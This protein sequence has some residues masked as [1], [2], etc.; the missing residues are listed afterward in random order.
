MKF[1]NSIRDKIEQYFHPTYFELENESHKHKVPAGSETHFRLLVVS[2]FFKEM[3]RV[4]RARKA[5]EILADELSSGV[6]ALSERFFT[7]DEW[8]RLDDA[9]KLMISPKC[10]GGGKG[11]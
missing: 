1:E 6:H 4:E 5:H 8:G 2:D 10:L 7:L 3:T 9:Q 11:H